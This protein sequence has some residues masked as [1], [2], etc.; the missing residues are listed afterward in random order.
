M[1]A[2][3]T[4]GIKSLVAVTKEK[5]EIKDKIFF[6]VDK[7]TIQKKSFDLLN[8]VASVLKNYKY[9]TKNP[10]RGSTDS[11]G[12]KAHNMKLSQDRAESVRAYLVEHGIDIKRLDAQGFGPDRP[13]SSNKTAKGKEMNRRVEFV[14]VEQKAIG[15]D[16]SE[17]QKPRPRRQA[18]S[19]HSKF[20]AQ[21][22]HLVP[23]RPP[24]RRRPKAVSISASPPTRAAALRPRP[25]R[26]P[27]SPKRVRRKRRRRSKKTTCSSTS[28]DARKNFEACL[29]L[30]SDKASVFVKIL[31]KR[32]DGYAP[33]CFRVLAD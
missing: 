30:R 10:H 12:Q 22:Q 27:K 33:G 1:A 15:G 9:I 19:L 28:D 18:P 17:G 3:T 11:Q 26:R 13:I 21:R 20:R 8:Q 16:V 24:H 5:I 29:T 7:A 23:L 31:V 14:I 32:H 2:R 25:R 6:D 4:R